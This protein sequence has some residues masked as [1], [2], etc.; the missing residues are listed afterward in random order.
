VTPKAEKKKKV[1]SKQGAEGVQVPIAQ[2]APMEMSEDE[3]KRLRVLRLREQTASRDLDTSVLDSE[4]A[5]EW[6]KRKALM[7]I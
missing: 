5:D 7:Q 6:A 1:Y 4:T 2:P 3:R